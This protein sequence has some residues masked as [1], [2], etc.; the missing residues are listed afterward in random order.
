M[1]TYPVEFHRRLEQS[2][3]I[4]STRFSAASPTRHHREI[5]TTMMR[6]TKTRRTKTKRT[7]TSPTNRR[8]SANP[9]KT[10][11]Y[12]TAIALPQHKRPLL[13]RE[14]QDAERYSCISQ[15]FND[16]RARAAHSD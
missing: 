15:N 14:D 9:M 8:S 16:L 10:S 3:Q 7:K 2:R 5:P 11:R 12:G 4:A 6:R 13:Q 1:T